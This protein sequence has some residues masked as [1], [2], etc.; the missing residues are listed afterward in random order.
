MTI[1]SFRYKANINK[2]PTFQ[3]VPENPHMEAT[4]YMTRHFYITITRIDEMRTKKFSVYFSQGSAHKKPPT[5]EDVLDCL[6][7][8]ASTIENSSS[9]EDWASE[10]GYEQDSRK[11]EKTY[12]FCL[13]QSQKLKEFLGLDLYNTLLWD[14]ERL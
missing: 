10:L 14:T 1:E 12:N 6:A 2:Y 8:D 13:K 3:N 4:E 5:L 11:A 7:S 9:F